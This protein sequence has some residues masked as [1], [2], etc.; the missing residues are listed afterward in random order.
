[1]SAYIVNTN[2]T[3]VIVAA[4]HKYRLIK[5]GSADVIG[6]AL[7]MQ[8]HRAM[9]SR[10][11]EDM[12]AFSDYTYT[13]FP[14]LLQREA[15]DGAIRCW[16]YQCSEFFGVEDTAIS[17]LVEAARAANLL[18]I[19]DGNPDWAQD[20]CSF[21]DIHNRDLVMVAPRVV[22]ESVTFGS[23]DDDEDED[24]YLENEEASEVVPGSAEQQRRDDQAAEEED[25]D[26]D[27][28]DEEYGD[29]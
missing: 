27:E 29:D 19:L 3:D 21:W 5:K 2:T 15:I 13:E 28:E 6:Q 16:R 1:M 20:R 11:G 9:A 18:R 4:L 23:Y 8:N 25:E 10:Y 22:L 7:Q 17:K 24:G 14:R 26:E 12:P